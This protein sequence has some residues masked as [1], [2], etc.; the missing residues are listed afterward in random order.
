MDKKEFS[1]SLEL[2]QLGFANGKAPGYPLTEKEK[3]KMV[4]KAEKAYGV[5]CEEFEEPPKSHTQIWNYVQYLAKLGVLK[6]E[7][8]AA[9][10]RGRTNRISLP[11][12]PSVEL[13]REMAANLSR[14]KGDGFGD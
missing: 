7:V 14:E 13:E 9:E 10:S 12:I 8:G 5:V 6:A 4:D 1:D 2:A 11:T 3:W